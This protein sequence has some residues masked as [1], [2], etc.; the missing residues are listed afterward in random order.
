[1]DKILSAPDVKDAYSCGTNKDAESAA[2]LVI[3]KTT[4]AQQ[5]ETLIL[6]IDSSLLFDEN[7][8]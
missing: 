8:I 3:L 4:A 5:K 7:I 6:L 1:M 2:W